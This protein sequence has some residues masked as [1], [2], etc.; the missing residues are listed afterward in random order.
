[1]LFLTSV[2]AWIS[3]NI[4]SSKGFK[5]WN[6]SLVLSTVSREELSTHKKANQNWGSLVPSLLPY[7][8]HVFKT[9]TEA[10]YSLYQVIQGGVGGSSRSTH[11]ILKGATMSHWWKLFSFKF[12]LNTAA[13]LYKNN[14][15][16]E[17]SASTYLQVI[18]FEMW[19]VRRCLCCYKHEMN[20]IFVVSSSAGQGIALAGAESALLSLLLK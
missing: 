19:S 9:W 18:K 4:V 1:M 6:S 12:L 20:S 3:E 2:P 16:E 11:M 7:G 8:K 10:N 13:Y 5:D 17:N 15:K 14:K